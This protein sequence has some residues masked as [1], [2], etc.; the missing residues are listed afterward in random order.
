MADRLEERRKKPR[1]L[2][3]ADFRVYYKGMNNE[4]AV[5]MSSLG[6]PFYEYPDCSG[7]KPHGLD[8]WLPSSPPQFLFPR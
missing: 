6:L 1:E 7:S 8:C 3:S 2:E 5:G 4:Y